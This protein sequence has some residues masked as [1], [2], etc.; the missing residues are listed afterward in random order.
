L[1]RD[2]AVKVL[3][4]ELTIDAARL[5]RFER[6]ARLL[7]ALNHPNIATIHG[8]EDAGGY[9]AIV[10]ELVEGLTLADR[11]ARAPVPVDEALPIARQIADALEAAHERG[12]IHRDLKPANIKV[13]PKR[14]VKV[15][16]FGIAKTLVP[17]DQAPTGVT[18]ERTEIGAIIGTPAYMSPEQ[19]R[20]GIVDQRTDI[21]AFGCVFYETLAGR[22][23][24]AGRTAADSIAAIL[25]PGPDWTALPA[26]TPSG[27]RRVLR[28]CLEKDPAYRLHDI[29]DTRADLMEPR[30]DGP[31]LPEQPESSLYGRALAL[32]GAGS[33]YR[34]WE[35]LQIRMG[36]LQYPVVVFL[37]WKATSAMPGLPGGLLFFAAVV[38]VL[39]LMTVRVRLL[40]TGAV[41]RQRLPKQ[42]RRAAPWLRTCTVAVTLLLWWMAALVV[43][44]H[45][46]L[47]TLLG[48]IGAAETVTVVFGEPPIERAAFPE[49]AAEDRYRR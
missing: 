24:F 5:T 11:I 16:D 48:V 42:V 36:F 32:F 27:V 30:A 17:D 35:M 6:E 8:I 1:A 41:E 37:S 40:T 28:R 12:I 15:L 43:A 9:P 20:G 19:V 34:L 29:A 2:V 10:M 46:I 38:S 7:A 3:P 47:A 22:A 23:A 49:I 4:A 25:G 14:L 13:T 45:P 33:P 18:V 31:A 26:D 39:V 21:W 44:S